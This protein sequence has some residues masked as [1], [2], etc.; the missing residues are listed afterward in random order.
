MN[1][2]GVKLIN[3]LN[4]G[5]KGLNKNGISLVEVVISV[6]LIAVIS[7]VLYAV[8]TY[9]VDVYYS[10][11]RYVKQQDTVIQVLNH[12]RGDVK[13]AYKFEVDDDNK[14]LTLIDS[15]HTQR[16]WAIDDNKLKF[17]DSVGNEQDV[18]EGIDTENSYF[19]YSDSEKVIVLKIQPLKTNLGKYTARNINKPITTEFSVKYKEPIN[20]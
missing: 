3:K 1:C 14:V 13:N 19:E 10:Y 9:G 16:I 6:A 8:F 20:P 2:Y 11:G 7:P 15:E 4:K 18:V 17:I 5:F 12:L